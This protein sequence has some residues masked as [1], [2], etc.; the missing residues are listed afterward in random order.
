M[1]AL[2][3][4]ARPGTRFWL[5]CPNRQGLPAMGPHEVL[6]KCALAN[7]DSHNQNK[8]GRGRLHTLVSASSASWYECLLGFAGG[9][10]DAPS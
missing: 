1:T 2:R 5:S 7:V 10:L 6:K 9:F 4:A 3:S 8:G